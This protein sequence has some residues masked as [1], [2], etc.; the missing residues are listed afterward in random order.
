VTSRRLLWLS[1]GV[2]AL[3]LG[4]PA[5]I[6]VMASEDTGTWPFFLIAVALGA[7][8]GWKTAWKEMRKRW[9][10][11]RVVARIG[12]ELGLA[13]ERSVPEKRMR[14]YFALPLFDMLHG[15]RRFRHVMSGPVGE[16]SVLLFDYEPV[17]PQNNAARTVILFPDVGLPEFE[18][19]PRKV[20]HFLGKGLHFHPEELLDEF[21]RQLM[22]QFSS[23]YTVEAMEEEA[24]R[25]LFSMEK[26][27]LLAGH[28]G[29]VVQSYGGHLLLC[30]GRKKV[31]L[32]ERPALFREGLALAGLFHPPLC[33][34]DP[35][36]GRAT[37]APWRIRQKPTRFK[38]LPRPG[39]GPSSDD[40]F[41]GFE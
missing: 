10:E 14:R 18:M 1:A 37:P 17:S 24:V 20:W 11:L 12:K 23:A 31:P 13:C 8:V 15:W 34:E 29:W 39:P 2:G 35:W 32:Q 40:R 41:V 7:C 27:A 3:A 30:K 6:L 25:G 38:D 21:G 26:V 19:R 5:G 4:G 28:P 16:G 22:R 36:G 33:P 9:A